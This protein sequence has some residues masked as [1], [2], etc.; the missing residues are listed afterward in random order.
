V[1]CSGGRPWWWCHTDSPVPPS[2]GG[3]QPVSRSS[4]CRRPLVVGA[5][6]PGPCAV[7]MLDEPVGTGGG[8]HPELGAHGTRWYEHVR[9]A[10]AGR[11]PSVSHRAGPTAAPSP[12]GRPPRPR[13]CSRSPRA[14]G[15][16]RRGADGR[17]GA[18]QSL[19]DPR[20]CHGPVGAGPATFPTFRHREP[21]GRFDASGPAESSVW[22]ES[23]RPPRAARIRVANGTVRRPSCPRGTCT[24]PGKSG[25]RSPIR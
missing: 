2:L 14:V 15:A 21:P 12:G 5:G 8:T 19:A 17:S 6:L 16:K 10:E 7:V 22:T 20:R 13:V 11:T 25:R 23:A 9:C 1:Q 24:E 4:A 3:R 18:G